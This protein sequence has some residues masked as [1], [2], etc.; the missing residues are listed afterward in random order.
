MRLLATA[1]AVALAVAQDPTA[2]TAPAP[3]AAAPATAPPHV[4][5]PTI[6]ARPE[7]V[8]TVESIIQATY[9]AI[10]GPAGQP[11]QWGRDRALYVPDVVLVATG[12]LRAKDGQTRPF[13]KVMD[14]QTYVDRVD[15]GFVREGFFERE[16]H[17]VAHR[18]GNIAHV[19]STYESR[20]TAD[21]PV[22]DRGV[23][24]FQL[25]FDGARWWIA[26][27]AWESERPKNPIPKELLP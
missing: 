23:N 18:F 11:R 20:K 25:Y 8:A 9:E 10:S 14:Y 27:L 15:P 21:G 7:D 19:L 17:R 26:S 16:I 2:S 4:E 1:L 3:P 22:T 13:A 5:I 24:S 12:M 6:A